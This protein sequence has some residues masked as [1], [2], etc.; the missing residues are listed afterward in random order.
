MLNI[1]VSLRCEGRNFNEI[2]EV[3]NNIFKKYTEKSNKYK[4]DF[5][6]IKSLISTY[7]P[8]ESN[9]IEYLG[10]SIEKMKDADVV[11]VPLDHRK[12]KGCTIEAL[13]AKI[14]GLPIVTYLL[15]AN[16]NSVYFL[17]GFVE[18]F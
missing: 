13:T 2:K 17:D 11:L 18:T 3:Q 14:Y 15:D 9:R 12:S 7:V 1:F 16:S 5:Y 8:G 6:L 10:K 4:D